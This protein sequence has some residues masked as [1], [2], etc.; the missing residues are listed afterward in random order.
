MF[1]KHMSFL[2]T[3]CTCRRAVRTF[4]EYRG[5]RRK[6]ETCSKLSLVALAGRETPSPNHL[7]SFDSTSFQPLSH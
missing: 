6:E 4:K 3:Y 7:D 5:L 1:G 2:C